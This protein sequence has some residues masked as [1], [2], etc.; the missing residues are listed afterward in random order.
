MN[1]RL[2]SAVC[3]PEHGPELVRQMEMLVDSGLKWDALGIS[4]PA[5]KEGNM[6]DTIKMTKE[7]EEVLSGLYLA[8]SQHTSITWDLDVVRAPASPPNP[9]DEQVALATDG[10][11]KMEDWGLP[12][13][14]LVELSNIADL[15]LASGTT[16]YFPDLQA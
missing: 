1:K 9:T 3:H 10:I 15:L 14:L 7:Q 11:L 6:V 8:P 5:I 12:E 2:E 13:D 4:L 16:T